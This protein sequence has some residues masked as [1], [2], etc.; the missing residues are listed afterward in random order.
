[1][2]IVIH[3][4]ERKDIVTTGAIDPETVVE[5]HGH[6]PDDTEWSVEKSAEERVQ[7]LEQRISELESESGSYG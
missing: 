5:S 6:D 2:R 1:M 3:G 7:E 4:D